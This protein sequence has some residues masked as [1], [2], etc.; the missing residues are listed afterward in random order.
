M[1]AERAARAIVRAGLRGRPEIILTLAAQV[2]VRAHGLA[3]ELTTR[4]LRL[5]DRMLPVDESTIREPGHV[6]A[7]DAAWFHWLTTFTRRAAARWH[8]ANDRTGG[9]GRP[10]ISQEGHAP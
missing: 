3:P 5:V 2:A 9:D 8:E 1:D 10:S 7:T 4:L 6:V